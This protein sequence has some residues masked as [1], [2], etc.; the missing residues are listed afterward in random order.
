MRPIFFKTEIDPR[1]LSMQFFQIAKQH[2]GR[3]RHIHG[4]LHEM[5]CKCAACRKV[6]A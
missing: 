3:R 4:P 5:H 2:P 6:E 1:K